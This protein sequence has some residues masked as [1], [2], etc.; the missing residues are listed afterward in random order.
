M[1]LFE[2]HLFVCCNRREPG[3]PRGCCADKGSEKIREALKAELKRRGLT[4]KVRANE[5]GCLDQCEFG[6][7]MVIY[8]QQVWYGGLTEADIPRIVEETLIGGRILEDL[9]IPDESLNTKGK[10]P[11]RRTT[12]DDRGPTG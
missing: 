1:P 5:A 4:G 8:P 7:T 6:P 2:C 9:R 12:A 11:W 10:I 3:H